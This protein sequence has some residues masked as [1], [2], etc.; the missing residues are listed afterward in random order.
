MLKTLDS[1]EHIFRSLKGI[2]ME[3][4]T[5]EA[6][7]ART[8]SVLMA[9]NYVGRTNSPKGIRWYITEKGRRALKDPF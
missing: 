3:T 8:L 6:T 5:D 7:I 1:G 4:N 2:C 9:R